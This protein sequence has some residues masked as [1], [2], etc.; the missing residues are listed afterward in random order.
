MKQKIDYAKVM[1]QLAGFGGDEY[2][3][4]EAF[5]SKK[6]THLVIG[7]SGATFS[8]LTIR[9]VD[10]VT[11]RGLT[12]ISLPSGYILC[13]GN[14]D[15]FDSGTI[16]AGS[17]Q[18][19]RMQEDP[20]VT[21]ES[22]AVEDGT[23]ATGMTATLTFGNDGGAG[24]LEVDCVIEDSEETVIAQYL[25]SEGT[26]IQ[27]YFLPGESQTATIPGLTYPSDAGTDY[28][29]RVKISGDA[30]STEVEDTFDVTE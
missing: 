28:A 18:G 12:E 29:I 9:G 11:N 30:D 1:A 7:S 3:G 26:A 6:F 27:V 19:L 22:V 15:Y 20:I 13:A 16:S 2:I 23:A 17:A 5:S 8:A 24:S 14:D 21:L 10:I 4:A 25:R